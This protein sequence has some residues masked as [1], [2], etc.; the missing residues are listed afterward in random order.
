M[1]QKIE[2]QWSIGSDGFRR[3]T[4][5]GMLLVTTNRRGGTWGPVKWAVFLA[6]RVE[7]SG[8]VWQSGRYSALVN[9]A[10]FEA[11]EAAR[12]VAFDLLVG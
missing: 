7:R 5:N 8:E 2:A 11:E 12:E 6:G 10:M 3:A 4:V 1:V 9:Q